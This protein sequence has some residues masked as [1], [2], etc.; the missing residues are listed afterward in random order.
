MFLSLFLQPQLGQP[1]RS[2]LSDA[3]MISRG[4]FET[5][6]VYG[7]TPGFSAEVLAD[8]RIFVALG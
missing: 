2:V 1:N 4:C 3:G 6:C 7:V 5:F 8:F